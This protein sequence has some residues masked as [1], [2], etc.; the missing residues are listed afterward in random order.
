MRKWYDKSHEEIVHFIQTFSKQ[1]KIDKLNIDIAM[2]EYVYNILKYQIPCEQ[3]QFGGAA[4]DKAKDNMANKRAEMYS[5]VV[6]EIKHGLCIE[7]FDLTGELKREL[8]MTTWDRMP[9][10]RFILTKKEVLRQIL[11]GSPDIADAL[12]L[13][14][15]DRWYGDDPAMNSSS[16]NNGLSRDEE[17]EI[18]S[19]Y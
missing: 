19:E 14:C 2:S 6:W 17:E 3:I 16:G 11:G 12:A 7:G 8:C 18:M 1:I 9:N 10:G 15:V 13:T 4:S 5:N